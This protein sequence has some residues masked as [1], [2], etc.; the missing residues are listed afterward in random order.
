MARAVLLD[1][2]NT[3]AVRSSKGLWIDAALRQIGS[4]DEVAREALTARLS[5]VWLV[6][7]SLF[8]AE[9]WDLHPAKHRS[10][11]IAAISHDGVATPALAEALYDVMPDQVEMNRGA[12]DFVRAIHD[13]GKKLAIV[14]NTALDVRPI[15]QRWG[16]ESLFDAVVLS[17]EVG[18]VKPD[19]AI[20]RVAARELGV[21][22]PDCVM[23]GDTPVDDTGAVAVGMQS[24]IAQPEQMWRAFELVLGGSRR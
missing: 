2:F 13:Q 22:A 1:F 6:A 20:F 8:P 4:G 10:T 11:F 23:I 17:Y 18:C 5:Q 14:S 7:R 15:L 9:N 3:L 19:P 16:L 21:E 24:L 12:E